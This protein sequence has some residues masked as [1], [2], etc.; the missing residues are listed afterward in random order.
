MLIYFRFVISSKFYLTGIVEVLK[1]M[2]EMGVNPDQETYINYVFP[3]FDSVTSV[4]AILQ[5]SI[6]MVLIS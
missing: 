1:G 2:H 4:R 6:H 3:S 5:V